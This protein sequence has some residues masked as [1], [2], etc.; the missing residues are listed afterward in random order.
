[1]ESE[2]EQGKVLLKQAEWIAG[3]MNEVD[4]F[5]MVYRDEAEFDKKNGVKGRLPPISKGRRR[6]R[7]EDFCVS[8]LKVLSLSSQTPEDRVRDT[9]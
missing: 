8:G 2:R 1:M 4:E 9:D 3:E 6:E 5:E 7:E